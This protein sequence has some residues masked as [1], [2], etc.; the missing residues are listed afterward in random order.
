MDC[1]IEIKIDSWQFHKGDLGGIWEAIRPCEKGSPEASLKWKNIKTPHC[2]NDKD[3]LNPDINYYQGP[4]WYRT[5][6]TVN[7]P[8]K[9]GN[10]FLFF[11]G[12]GQITDVYLED[13]HIKTHIGGYDEWK[14]DLT[15]YL[16]EDKNTYNLVIRCDN[17]R[18]LEIMPSD[19]SDFNIYGGLYRDVSL[20]YEPNVYLK[21][22]HITPIYNPNDKSGEIRLLSKFN[23]SITNVALEISIIENENNEIYN[24][25][26]NIINRSKIKTKINLNKVKAWSP[27]L[28][29]LYKIKLKYLDNNKK[30]EVFEDFGFRSFYFEKHGPFILNGEKYFLKGTHRHEDHAGVGAAQDNDSITYEMN[31]IKEMG[32]NFIRLGHYQQSRKV[33]N[34]C[35]KLGILVWEE[36]P[37]CRGGLGNKNYQKIGKRL[38]KNMINQHYNHPSIILWG[39]GNENDWPGDFSTFNQQD[40][41]NY[42]QELN[43][44]AHKLD[45]RRKTSI[46]RCNFC[47]DII[48]VYSPSIWAGWYRGHYK[49]YKESTIKHIKE[50]NH[51]LHV[52]WGA[53]SH[54]N[55]FTEDPYKGLENLKTGIG[56][57]ERDNDASLYG[58]FSRVSKDGNWSENYCCDLFDW[59][60][61]EQFSIPELSGS[62]FWPFKDF[63]TPLREENPIPYVNQK[64]VVQ[65]DFTK[66][67]VYYVV[68]SYWSQKPMVRLFG[69]QWKNRCGKEFEEKEFRVYSNC[70]KAQLFLDG[71]DL[72]YKERNI[73]DF[74]SSGLRW[75]APL[76]YGKHSLRVKAY[77]EN[78]VLEDGYDFFY[79]TD[80]WSTPA[81]INSTF[82]KDSENNIL[83]QIEV[84]DSNNVR[85]LDFE[86]RV[87][88]SSTDLS[89]LITDM[90]TATGSRLIECTNGR[91]SIK[92]NTSNKP[93]I[94]SAY[95]EGLPLC[96]AIYPQKGK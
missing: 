39:L 80:S 90:G 92:L 69:H 37:W 50:V 20:I 61:K 13:K 16:L 79:Q 9:K 12:S 32:A 94:L 5:N 23:K 77:F 22:L 26:I 87:R 44:I 18:N 15:P 42:M 3:A 30:I 33:L 10:T 49:E 68:Q 93:A 88:F 84:V 41:R 78:E 67:E 62:A 8:Y 31:L 34:L 58:G 7:N 57:D 52:E 76:K 89:A 56:T 47:K 54:A 24:I 19:L 36:I 11:E 60:L 74:P 46:R 40:I 96:S 48:D 6:I 21:K 71:K 83:W 85:C 35:D 2:F 70:K 38:L 86:K 65:R 64:G 4:G 25:K 75:K 14:V 82:I 29:F 59:T 95:I 55:R 81:K 91:S 53:D 66:K 63:S 45:K 17:S 72:G 51:F 43:S 27:D 73:N 1:G 28:P